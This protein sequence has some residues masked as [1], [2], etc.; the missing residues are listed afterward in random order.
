M[1]TGSVQ[2]RGEPWPALPVTHDDAGEVRRVGVE[3]EVGG[4]TVA[5]AVEAVIEVFGGAAEP[6]GPHQVRVEGTEI[7]PVRV[8]LDSR[9]LKRERHR[10]IL[11]SLGLDRAEG[12]LAEV[13]DE[14]V[15]GT[16]SHFVPCEVI[17]DPLTLPEAARLEALREALRG[18]GAE[19]TLAEPWYAFGV[20]FNPSL[21]ATDGERLHAF[22]QAFCLLEDW[23]REDGRVAFARKISPYVDP[24]PE[25]Y[26]E[27]ILAPGPAPS[28]EAL[29]DRYLAH[30]PTRNRGLDMLP[31][32]AHLDPD[33]VEAVVHDELVKARPA[34]HYRLGDC[35]VDDPSWRLAEEWATWIEVERLAADDARRAR[36]V[37]LGVRAEGSRRREGDER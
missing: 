26:R 19:G 33:R 30:N 29:I 7:G 28:R 4:L 21:P 18:R 12:R 20:H 5:A 23:I 22:L 1:H 24:F 16:A 6:A 35:R 14:L 31:A 8:E 25:A 17:T 27:E 10:D 37:E 9:F 34:F 3:I 2:A 15:V 11:E 32:F 13:V 36:L